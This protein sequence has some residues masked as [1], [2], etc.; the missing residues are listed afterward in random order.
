MRPGSPPKL[1]AFLYVHDNAARAWRTISPT[2][3][4]G[5]RA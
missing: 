3:T 2:V 4:A 1:A 5:H